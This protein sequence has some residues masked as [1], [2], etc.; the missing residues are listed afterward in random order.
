MTGNVGSVPLHL[1]HYIKHNKALHQR[2][3]LLSVQT[4]RV[5]EVPDADRLALTDLGAGF[6]QLIARYGYMQSPDVPM[7]LGRCS[8]LP[9]TEG[10]PS[11]YLGRETL[12][13]TGKRGMPRWQKRLFAF[14]HDNARP[15]TAYFRLPPNRVVELGA[16]IEL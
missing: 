8:V 14:L 7:L 6:Y 16:Q 2:V 1:L 11:Y 12:L 13:A 15:I 4:E 10:P 9:G 5:P 3:L